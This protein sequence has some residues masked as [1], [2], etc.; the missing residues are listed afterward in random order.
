MLSIPGDRYK[1]EIYLLLTGSILFLNNILLQS[2]LKK[3][4]DR[5]YQVKKSEKG[6]FCFR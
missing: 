1:Y 2:M 3:A 6:T 5:L 4:D